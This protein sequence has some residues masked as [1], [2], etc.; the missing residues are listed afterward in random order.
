MKW[1]LCVFEPYEICLKCHFSCNTG[2]LSVLCFYEAIYSQIHFVF[3]F[4]F[5]KVMK[6]LL[7]TVKYNHQIYNLKIEKFCNL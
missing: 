5:H 6:I 4:I 1:I 7:L 3:L 2:I